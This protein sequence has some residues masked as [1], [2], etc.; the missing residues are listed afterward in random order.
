M[1]GRESAGRGNALDIGE[2]QASG[3]ER[4]DSFDVAQP[5]RRACQGRQ[6]GRNLAGDRH[7]HA[8]EVR[9]RVA[10]DDRSATTASATGRPGSKR[11]PD[12]EQH[13]RDSADRK[14]HK[15]ELAELPSEQIDSFE[16]IMAAAGERQTGSATGSWRWSAR[17][18]S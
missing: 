4:N 12:Q 9:T 15:S 3:R 5:Q 7:A 11:S 6:P 2:Q 13:D 17:R 1:L 18:R 14:H 8:R 10:S 16:K